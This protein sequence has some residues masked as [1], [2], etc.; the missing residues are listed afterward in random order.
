MSKV[1]MPVPQTVTAVKSESPYAG[2]DRRDLRA[3]ARGICEEIGQLRRSPEQRGVVRRA[4][5]G[6]TLEIVAVF[7][8]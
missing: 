1:I 8:Q 2:H 3:S 6:K 4:Q 7:Q 5:A